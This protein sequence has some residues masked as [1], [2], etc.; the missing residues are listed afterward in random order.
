MA[1]ALMRG[2]FTREILNRY[3][4][5]LEF[6]SE[7]HNKWIWFDAQFALFAKDENDALLSAL[8][9]HRAMLSS[10]KVTFDFI[11]KRESQDY[12]KNVDITLLA[13]YQSYDWPKQLTLVLGNGLFSVDELYVKLGWVRSKAILQML[14]FI[15]GYTPQYLDFAIAS[16]EIHRGKYVAYYFYLAFALLIFANV[17]IFRT[18]KQ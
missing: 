13:P 8:E 5:T 9:L 11:G 17:R 12:V 15:L 2:I 10:R 6:W 1:L 16:E 3:H 14:G 18:R 4:N 7:D